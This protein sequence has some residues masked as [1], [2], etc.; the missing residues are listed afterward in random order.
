MTEINNDSISIFSFAKEAVRTFFYG[1][2]VNNI[3]KWGQENNLPDMLLAYF[4]SIPEHS[5]AIQF[6]NDMVVGEGISTDDLDIWT[7]KKLALD[8]ILFGSFVLLREGKINGK[9][10]TLKWLDM[11]KCRLT[12]DKQNII[13]HERNLFTNIV[14]KSSYP[15]IENSKQSG[16][17]FYKN[18][19]GRDY[20]GRPNY[21][22]AIRCLDTMNNVVIFNQDQ[23]ANNFAPTVIIN[24]PEKPNQER[25]KAFEKSFKDK[26]ISA[27]GQKFMTVFS[28]NPENKLTVEEIKTQIFDKSFEVLYKTLRNQIMIGHRM[29]GQLIGIPNETKGFNKTEYDESLKMFNDIVVSGIRLELEFGLSQFFGKEIQFVDKQQVSNVQ[30]STIS[31]QNNQ[32]GNQ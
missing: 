30:Q 3:I 16:V 29:T 26:F 18:P 13:Y 19:L 1:V 2:D 12:K 22:S 11:S 9:T 32:G 24:V 23:S 25:Q 31:D 17:Y 27:T 8:Y 15:I 7:V 10:V 20:Y 21:L 5:S 4:D 28:E 6:I 14:E